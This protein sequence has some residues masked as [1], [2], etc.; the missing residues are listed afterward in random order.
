MLIAYALKNDI[1]IYV[2][3]EQ[4]YLY[5][6]ISAVGDFKTDGK[7]KTELV[8]NNLIPNRNPADDK[9][10]PED[11]YFEDKTLEEIKFDL[12]I[13]LFKNKINS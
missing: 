4:L 2:S 12:C 8:E 9:S 13:R 11:F 10:Y 5:L 7:Y 1:P 3:K 6:R